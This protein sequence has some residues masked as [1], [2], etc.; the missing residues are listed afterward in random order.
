MSITKQDVIEVLALAVAAHPQVPVDRSRVDAY[1]ELLKDLEIDRTQLL[2]AVKAVLQSSTWFPSVALIR[3]Q[4]LNKPI[5]QPQQ[6]DALE[7]KP[8]SANRT[9]IDALVKQCHETLGKARDENNPY[10]G[11]PQY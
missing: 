10:V 8:V 2:G 3:E 6:F 1:Y 5:Q 7:F 4:I 11:T 9:R